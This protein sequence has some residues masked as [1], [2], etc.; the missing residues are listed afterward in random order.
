MKNCLYVR[1]DMHHAPV[2][3]LV[4]QCIRYIY[5]YIYYLLHNYTDLGAWV[6]A[7]F[8][9]WRIGRRIQIFVFSRYDR[10]YKVYEVYVG[11][12][13][14]EEGEE[15]GL[16]GWLA[17]HSKTETSRFRERDREKGNPNLIRYICQTQTKLGGVF[18]YIQ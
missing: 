4:G 14:E 7:T 6:H 17:V 5:I 3:L 1:P 9:M 18:F 15:E 2:Y 12:E 11:R 13:K 10:T 16:T 8:T